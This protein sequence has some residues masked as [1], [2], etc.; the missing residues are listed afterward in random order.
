VFP[1]L[2]LKRMDRFTT[3]SCKSLIGCNSRYSNGL[4]QLLEGFSTPYYRATK[5]SA[6][7][8]DH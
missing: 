5:P 6:C 7:V 3:V 1:R 8:I 4:H 2:D